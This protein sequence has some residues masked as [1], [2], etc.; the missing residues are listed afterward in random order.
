MTQIT[1][2][3]LEKYESL[4]NLVILITRVEGEAY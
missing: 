2:F 3:Y 1:E 4:E